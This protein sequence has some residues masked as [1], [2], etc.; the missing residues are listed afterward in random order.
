MR[1]ALNPDADTDT[2][3][4]SDADSSDGK[5]EVGPRR[6]LSRV[7]SVSGPRSIRRKVSSEAGS[8]IG[9]SM[10]DLEAMHVDDSEL[11]DPFA[12]DPSLAEEK[13]WAIARRP[14]EACMVT[15]FIKGRKVSVEGDGVGTM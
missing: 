5:S 8:G 14:R 2:E 4:G 1:G 11:D 7:S 15:Q 13:R 3:A 6:R 9:D 12:P 10:E